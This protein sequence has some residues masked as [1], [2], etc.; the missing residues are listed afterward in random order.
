[1]NTMYNDAAAIQAIE[2]QERE[3]S[4]LLN[5]VM[6]SPLAP[7]LKKMND[8]QQRLEVVESVCNETK[9]SD[10]PAITATLFKQG[11]ETKNRL[12]RMKQALGDD[13]EEIISLKLG[14]MP[15]DVAQ[16][17]QGQASIHEGLVILRE[18]SA[19]QGKAS[20]DAL[21]RC[22]SSLK[23]VLVQL[24]AVGGYAKSAGEKSDK[25]LHALEERTE[26]ISSRINSTALALDQ[27]G[28]FLEKSSVKLSE[29]LSQ[30]AHR[31]DS[32]AAQIE[33]FSVSMDQLRREQVDSRDTLEKLNENCA[34]QEKVLRE[35]FS[36]CDTALKETLGQLSL[37]NSHAKNVAEQSGRTL[38]AIGESRAHLESTFRVTAA[39]L[40]QQGSELQKSSAMLTEDLRRVATQTDIVA[41]LVSQKVDGI[42][43]SFEQRIKSL[44]Q[45]V[46]WLTAL[47]GAGLT[48]VL[49]LLAK[50]MM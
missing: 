20:S 36:Q 34:V 22:D 17:L 28:S 9:N 45:R 10:I 37:V 3:L 13:F 42:S 26:H 18:E 39:A 38:T 7:L 32:L 4:E 16:L 41:P 33:P 14:L 48:G 50:S 21:N 15:K 44:Q 2:Q 43:N 25:V 5:R 30:T 24:N 8:L 47:S 40:E 29:G 49:A 12:S 19:T 27:H 23:D 31:L 46:L 6:E 1:M 35:G 11:E